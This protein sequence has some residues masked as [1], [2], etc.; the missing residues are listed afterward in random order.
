MGVGVWLWGIGGCALFL[1]DKKEEV[2]ERG[3]RD[4]MR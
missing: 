3:R 2:G 1:G 4:G